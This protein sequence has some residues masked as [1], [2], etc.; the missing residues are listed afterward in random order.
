[1]RKERIQK[2]GTL[3]GWGC[4]LGGLEEITHLRESVSVLNLNIAIGIYLFS[5]GWMAERSLKPHS[6]C[7]SK[8]RFLVE[9]SREC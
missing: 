2:R 1:M 7:Y 8:R 5:A 6:V 9:L 4:M 3:A